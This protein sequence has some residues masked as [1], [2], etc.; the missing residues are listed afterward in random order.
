VLYRLVVLPRRERTWHRDNPE[1]LGG[2]VRIVDP[3]R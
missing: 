3:R 2:P 1:E